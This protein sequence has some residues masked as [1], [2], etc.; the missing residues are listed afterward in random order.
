MKSRFGLHSYVCW[1]KPFA[2]LFGL[3]RVIKN[4]DWGESVNQYITFLRHAPQVQA[5]KVLGGAALGGVG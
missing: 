2:M 3:S 4:K 1:R 5:I